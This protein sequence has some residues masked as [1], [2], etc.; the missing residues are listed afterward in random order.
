MDQEFHYYV[1][2]LIALESG[3]SHSDSYKIAFSAQFVDDNTRFYNVHGKCEEIATKYRN[4]ITS[5][6]NL[7]LDKRLLQRVF[8]TFHFPPGDPRKA[9]RRKDKR[10][11]QLVT[12]PGD[13]HSRRLLT[14]ALNK[15]NPYLIGIASHVY[16][17]TWAHQNFTG[18]W[19]TFNGMKTRISSGFI[20][21][22]GHMDVLTKP[23]KVNQVWYDDRLI[24]G[25][26]DNN[27]RY[28]EAMLN[29]GNAYGWQP[30]QSKRLRNLITS[31][32]RKHPRLAARQKAYVQIAWQRHRARIPRYKPLAWLHSAVIKHD[33]Q[34]HYWKGSL[35]RFSNWYLFQQAAKLYHRMR[36][37]PYSKPQ[38][39]LDK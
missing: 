24:K 28:L 34:Q 5:T 4:I 25:R 17:D 38:I 30:H 35:Y 15:R 37:E 21:R 13:R 36:W 6:Y 3:F 10:G 19:D 8:T 9:D 7:M 1:N 20:P 12:T 14:Q 32:W 22:L 26:V 16:A 27:I 39:R 33:D 18:T 29:I 23:D 11:H 31:L 2:Y